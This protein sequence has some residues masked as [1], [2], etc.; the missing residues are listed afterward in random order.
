VGNV[1]DDCLA[2]GNSEIDIVPVMNGKTQTGANRVA[3]HTRVTD[4]RYAVKMINDFRHEASRGAGVVRRNKI[5]DFIEICVS[6]IGDDQVFRRDRASPLEMMS[7]F[8]APAPG[9]LRNSPR[10]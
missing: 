1:Q 8:I 3:G 9:D 6:R 10:L 7:A 2:A 4:I 5:E